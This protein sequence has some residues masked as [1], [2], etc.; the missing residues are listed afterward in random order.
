MHTFANALKCANWLP[1]RRE[2][3]ADTEQMDGVASHPH[4]KPHHHQVLHRSLCCLPSFLHTKSSQLISSYTRTAEKP[5]K[6]INSST[7]NI[8]NRKYQKITLIIHRFHI[9][10]HTCCFQEASFSFFCFP[11]VVSSC[12]TPN[13]FTSGLQ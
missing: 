7:S 3:N 8:Q 9:E 11:D 2:S 1:Q 4:H 13:F 10:N 6:R 12:D 5:S